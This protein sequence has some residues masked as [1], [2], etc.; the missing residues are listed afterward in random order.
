MRCRSRAFARRPG[1]A[2]SGGPGCLGGVR[3]RGTF[4]SSIDGSMTYYCLRV[5]GCGAGL[6]FCGRHSRR[7]DS[8]RG[9]RA[10]AQTGHKRNKLACRSRKSERI[11]QGETPFQTV[12]A[13]QHRRVCAHLERKADKGRLLV[14]IAGREQMANLQTGRHLKQGHAGSNGKRHGPFSESCRREQP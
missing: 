4:P 13:S 2:G 6:Q 11:P 10:P 5:K 7:S 8:E 12:S 14:P 9:R 1:C 3:V